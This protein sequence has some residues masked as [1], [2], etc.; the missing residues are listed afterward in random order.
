[1][2]ERRSAN[3]K[4]KRSIWFRMHLHQKALIDSVPDETAGKAIKG[5]LSYFESGII[6]VCIQEDP[7]ALA[8]FS[9]IK[10]Y[11]DEII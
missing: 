10:Q 2:E 5:A 9:S 6:P 11:I 7:L 4:H 8:V 1:M 3:K